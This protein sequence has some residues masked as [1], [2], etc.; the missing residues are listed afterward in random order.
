[1]DTTP[2]TEAG[3][4]PVLLGFTLT[5]D[6]F[7]GALKARRGKTTQGRLLRLIAVA[8]S[9]LCVLLLILWAT[10]R[11]AFPWQMLLTAGITVAVVAAQPGLTGRAL[12]KGTQ[13][14]GEVR[15]TVDES[16]LLVATRTSSSTVSWQ[17]F[18]RYVETDSAFILLS[19]DKN[20]TC[21]NI[22]PKRA[23]AAP[24]D[25]DRLRALLDGHLPRA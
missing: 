15:T 21:L 10:G 22:L 5:A 9:V 6:D 19:P 1:M 4:E 16:G 11:G 24:A 18:G 20:G 2:R 14:N 12:A 3:P 23:A 17:T 13:R 8:G 7:A 25:I